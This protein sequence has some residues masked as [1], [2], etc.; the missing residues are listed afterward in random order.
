MAKRK[1]VAIEIAE[2]DEPAKI[3]PVAG[4]ND[5][6]LLAYRRVHLVGVDALFGLLEAH[7]VGCAAQSPYTRHWDVS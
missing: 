6:I 4:A 7:R 3:S 2:S 1:V 5:Q